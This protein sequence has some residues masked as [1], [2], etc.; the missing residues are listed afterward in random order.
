V[1]Q[2]PAKARLREE[3]ARLTRRLN[4]GRAD[5]ENLGR[6][7]KAHSKRLAKLDKDLEALRDARVRHGAVPCM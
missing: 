4:A 6:A 1:L 5:V 3:A 7:A 2:D